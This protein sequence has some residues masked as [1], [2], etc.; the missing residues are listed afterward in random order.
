MQASGG[1][2]PLAIALQQRL[3]VGGRRCGAK[4]TLWPNLLVIFNL[5]PPIFSVFDLLPSCFT[6]CVTGSDDVRRH[7]WNIGGVIP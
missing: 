7:L 1:G 3:Q 4:T 2:R 5:N 6:S